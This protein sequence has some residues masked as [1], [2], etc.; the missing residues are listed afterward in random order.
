[1]GGYMIDSYLQAIRK[2]VCTHCIDADERGNCRMHYDEICAV[3]EYLPNIITAV[4]RV[5]SEKIDDYVVELRTLV[6]SECRN[7]RP[8]GTCVVRDRLDCGL[9]RY[10]PLIIEAIEEVNAQTGVH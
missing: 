10:F 6:C 8:N 2:K 9:D 4:N 7:Q 3:E 5:Q 1:M